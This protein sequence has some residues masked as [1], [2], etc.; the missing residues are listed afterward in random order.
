MFFIGNYS[1]DQKSISD[2]GIFS[3]NQKNEDV[4]ETTVFV[5]VSDIGTTYG[6]DL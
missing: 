2:T 5:Y 6:D 4:F 1:P 3:L